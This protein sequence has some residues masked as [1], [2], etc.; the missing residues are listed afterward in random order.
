MPSDIVS[1]IRH[2][3]ESTAVD[4]TWA[5][6][7]SLT[8]LASPTEDGRAW[9][10]VD[11]EALVLA[12][13]LLSPVER[14]LEDLV[15]T[16]AREAGF[17]MSKPR[18]RSLASLFP[19]EVEGRIEDFARYAVEGGDSRWKSWARPQ[20]EAPA[21][22]EKPLGPLRLT[23]GPSLILRFR[24][25]FGVNAKADLL[26]ILLGMDGAAVDLKTLAAAAGYSERM[27]R[28]A[29]EEMVLAGF[30]VEVDGRP[31]SFYVEP[32]PWAE[33]L[34]TFPPEPERPQIPPWRFWTAI[35]AFLCHVI[36][37]ADTASEQ[38]WTDYVAA[39]RARD[40]YDDHE[41]RIRRAGVRVSPPPPAS[42]GERSLEVFREVV[43]GIRS[44]TLRNL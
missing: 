11:P 25:G 3:A 20:G 43:E 8:S 28:T 7:S 23:E 40:V 6:W 2:M 24:A 10:I 4:A 21:P 12:S 9:T 34:Y 41:G 44:W 37:W 32:E 26:A 33:V 15:A 27:I 39:S 19:E 42:Q 22:R 29:T 1:R 13:L 30:L 16:W 18:F 38:N 14:R 36:H 35:L 17:L 31:S 5:Q